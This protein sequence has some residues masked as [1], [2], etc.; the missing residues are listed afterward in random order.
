[1]DGI[2]PSRNLVNHLRHLFGRIISRF[3]RNTTIRCFEGQNIVDAISGHGDFMPLC[4]QAFY[5]AFLLLWC[6]PTKDRIL[7]RCLVQVFFR[8]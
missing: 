5:K 3:H 2:F 6:H 4:L 8:Q 1:M 7:A